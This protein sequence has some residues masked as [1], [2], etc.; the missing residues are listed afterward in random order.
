MSLHIIIIN[1]CLPDSLIP[2]I[3][4][5]LPDSLI[6]LINKPNKLKRNANYP[7]IRDD[8]LVKSSLRYI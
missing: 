5:C 4:K 2:L 8:I 1:N 7:S 6:P 3:N